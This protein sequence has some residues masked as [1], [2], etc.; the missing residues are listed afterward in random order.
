MK[1]VSILKKSGIKFQSLISNFRDL[2]IPFMK[3]YPITNVIEIPG[4][5][6]PFLGKEC[7]LRF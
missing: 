6:E 2:I 3:S 1:S 7:T 4:E 5:S